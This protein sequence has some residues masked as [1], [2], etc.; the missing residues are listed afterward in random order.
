MHACTIETQQKPCVQPKHYL[1]HCGCSALEFIIAC[2][3]M[4]NRC[5]S[6]V[7]VEF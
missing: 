7:Y 3:G 5:I 2:K 4:E 6:C 1:L